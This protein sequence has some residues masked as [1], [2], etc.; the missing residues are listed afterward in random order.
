MA[1]FRIP[2]KA[3]S[4]VL[5]ID[6]VDVTCHLR[7]AGFTETGGGST[8]LATWCDPGAAGQAPPQ[9]T[10][11]CEWMMSF[12]DGTTEGIYDLLKTAADGTEQAIV[13]T[14]FPGATAAPKWEFNA[15]VTAPL[16]E[17]AVDQPN[18]AS[19]SW[20]VSSLVYTKA[21]HA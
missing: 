20:G 3:L 11:D 1:V 16:G 15:V 8:D 12:G 10:F 4:G 7:R 14:P 6:G 13:F 19:T 9:L 21:V 2:P 5:T 18:V 17:F